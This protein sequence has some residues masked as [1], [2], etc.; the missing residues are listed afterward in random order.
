MKNNAKKFITYGLFLLVFAVSCIAGKG[1]M[2]KGTAGALTEY[3]VLKP[4][5]RGSITGFDLNTA[6]K[7]ALISIKG[8]GPSYAESIIEM[9]NQMG[10][11]KSV[12]DLEY[13]DG[14]GEKNARFIDKYVRID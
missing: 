2:S 14:I 9:R 3:E 6:T 12:H 4:P 5:R 10:Y 11:F 13:A 7:E 8:I 1:I